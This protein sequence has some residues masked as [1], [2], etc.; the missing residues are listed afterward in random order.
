METLR[1]L[2]R[3]RE[4]K[5]EGPLDA[6][7]NKVRDDLVIHRRSTLTPADVTRRDGIPVTT[8]ACTLIDIATTVSSARLEAAVNES[9]KLGL[10]D[11]ERLRAV[12]DQTPRRPGIAQM[13]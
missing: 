13:R 10:I 5:Q 2:R 9:D 4:A 8:P 12:L 3:A 6:A 7:M 11:P 1:S